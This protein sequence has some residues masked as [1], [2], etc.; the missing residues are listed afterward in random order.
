MTAAG[1]QLSLLAEREDWLE[2]APA[3]RPVVRLLQAFDTYLLGYAR[4]DFAVPPEA[5]RLV[6]RGGGWLHGV[7]LV[8]GLAVGALSTT[9]T[10]AGVHIDV[11][12][13]PGA[14]LRGLERP[15]DAEAAHI[16]RFLGEPVK[17]SVA[18]G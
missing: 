4:R 1:E 7:A 2:W 16:A 3:R 15:L 8:D 18:R 9:R 11:A 5:S 6:N 17:W 14:I 13:F 10:R 12:P